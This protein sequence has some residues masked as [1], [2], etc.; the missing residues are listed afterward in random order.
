MYHDSVGEFWYQLNLVAER[1][2]LVTLTS[3]DCELGRWSRQVISLG[4][5]TEEHLLLYPTISNPNNFMIE[6]SDERPLVLKAQSTLG[7][8][9]VFMPS[10][11]GSADQ[12]AFISFH[13]AQVC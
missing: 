11:L 5:P 10:R 8:P 1:P 6:C 3:M 13:C 12:S 7:I 9:V 4:N 2:S